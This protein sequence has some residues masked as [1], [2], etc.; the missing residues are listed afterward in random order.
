MVKV[1]ERGRVQRSQVL[2]RLRLSDNLLHLL[3]ILVNQRLTAQLLLRLPDE[4]L[5]ESSL[6]RRVI[7]LCHTGVGILVHRGPGGQSLR[8]GPNT[9]ARPSACVEVDSMCDARHVAVGP[10]QPPAVPARCSA[11]PCR[12][13]ELQYFLLNLLLSGGPS[14]SLLTLSCEQRVAPVPQAR[15]VVGDTGARASLALWEVSDEAEGRLR[16]NPRIETVD[17]IALDPTVAKVNVALVPGQQLA[18]TVFAVRVVT[19]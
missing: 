6:Q 9:R 13:R 3:S 14:R 10:R 15:A 2:R 18:R 12:V 5:L 7:F 4:L 19:K 17:Y 8:W 1:G 16:G 11:T